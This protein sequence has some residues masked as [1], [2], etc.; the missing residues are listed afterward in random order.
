MTT[1]MITVQQRV[2]WEQRGVATS[3]LHL[4]RQL[5]AT[6][7]VAALGMVFALRTAGQPVNAELHFLPQA[8]GGS[9]AAGATAAALANALQSLTVLCVAAAIL[10]V[11]LCFLLRDR[12]P[13]PH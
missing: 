12:D 1:L 11:A 8:Q 5:G 6:L 4:H 13:A 9:A 10:S 3:G 2:S 7:G